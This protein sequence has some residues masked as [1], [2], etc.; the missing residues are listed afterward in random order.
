M[1]GEDGIRGAE[2]LTAPSARP[3]NPSRGCRQEDA[4]PHSR[5]EFSSFAAGCH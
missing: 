2:L 4:A 5:D 3:H 1:Q